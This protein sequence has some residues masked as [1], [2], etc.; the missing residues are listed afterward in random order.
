M[1]QVSILE[2][3][4]AARGCRSPRGSLGHAP[5]VSELAGFRVLAIFGHDYLHRQ[6]GRSRCAVSMIEKR[7]AVNCERNE[8]LSMALSIGVWPWPDTVS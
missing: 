3:Q 6:A 8:A 1:R 2:M 5:Q 7:R 4:G